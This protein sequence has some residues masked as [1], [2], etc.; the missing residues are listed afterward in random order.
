MKLLKTKINSLK[1]VLGIYFLSIENAKSKAVKLTFL[2]VIYFL[3]ESLG[4][5]LLIPVIHKIMNGV[6]SKI[7]LGLPYFKAFEDWINKWGGDQQLIII[8]SIILLVTIFKAGIH[9][10]ILVST[11]SIGL[12]IGNFW[13]TKLFNHI[14]VSSFKET[15]LYKPGQFQNLLVTECGDLRFTCREILR[16]MSSLIIITLYSI[17]LLKISY[18][19][20]II[21]LILILVIA[22]PIYLLS[23]YI[24]GESYSRTTMRQNLSS[25]IIDAIYS[26]KIIH[27]FKTYSLESQRFQEKIDDLYNKE[28]TMLSKNTL[29]SLINTIAAITLPL[30]IIISAIYFFKN[31]QSPFELILFLMI[32]GKLFPAVQAIGTSISI[33]SRV[34]GSI[35]TVLRFNETLSLAT[36]KTGK[37]AIEKFP[38]TITFK[39]VSFSYNENQTI[40]NQVNL[41]INKGQHIA[42]V[43]PSGSGKSTLIGLLS[44]LFE[45]DSGQ[46]YLDEQELSSVNTDSWRK[47]IGLVDQSSI[48]FNDTI[49]NNV[50]YGIKAPKNEKVREACEMAYANDFI[51]KCKEGYNTKVGNLGNSLSG[52]QKQRIAIA[53]ALIREPELIILDEATSSIDSE[54]EM[55]VSQTIKALSEK[56]KTIISIAHR[57]STVRDADVIYYFDQGKII[58]S[59]SFESLLKNSQEFANFVKLQTLID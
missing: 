33:I 43:G 26:L 40:L 2:N 17:L 32:C 24:R 15:T 11:E 10:Y 38:D 13:R 46:L 8:S 47:F 21:V 59:G 56:G 45:P 41:S 48:L 23:K 39:D 9:R 16:V 28:Y 19:L 44:R 22:S 29:I 57:L 31:N 49:Y 37:I 5:S 50:T 7:E 53:R 1:K 20:T 12:K 58:A 35:D 18:Q 36:P 52:G 55:K 6:D 34:T 27:L 54:S 42:F 3:C 51:T 14:L 30:S 25:Y 4:I